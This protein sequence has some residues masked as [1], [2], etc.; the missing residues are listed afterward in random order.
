MNPMSNL[1]AQTNLRPARFPA[2]SF[3]AIF[4][5]DM[6]LLYSLALLLTAE[7][8]TA[9][10]CFQL[11]LKQCLEGPDVFCGWEG[12]WSRRAIVKEA[13]RLVR[14]KPGDSDTLLTARRADR[15][16]AP[17]RLLALQ[18]FERFVFAMTVLEKY[19]VRETAAL[20][21]TVPSEVAKARTRVFE[22]LGEERS[23]G[24]PDRRV[25]TV[26]SPAGFSASA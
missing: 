13:I 19:T 1:A 9:E 21:N 11:A 22:A 10:Q 23:A 14:P 2:K 24:P 12:S 16:D 20:L 4:E 5:K 25:W 6:H 7:H 8:R 15:D 17:S 18:P 3:C 26:S